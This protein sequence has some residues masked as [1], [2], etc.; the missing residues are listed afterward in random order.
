M[1]TVRTRFAPSPTGYM[2]IGNL[3]TALYEYLIA[4]SQGGTFILRIEDTDAERFVEGSV[5]AIYKTLAMCGLRHD[6]G[7][8]VGG[9]YGPYVQSQRKE[10]YLDHAR[11]LVAAGGAYYCFCSKERIDGLRD[12]CEA[13]HEV[14]KYDGHCKEIPKDEVAARIRNGEACVVRQAIPAGSTTIHDELFGD[15]TVDH[16]Q[17]DENVLLKSDGLPTYNFANVVDDHLM[18]ITHVVRGSEYLSSAPKYDLLYRAFGWEIPSYVHLPLIM[19][20]HSRKLSKRHGDPS[21]EDLIGAGFLKDA[22]LNYILLLG[23]NP[24]DGREFFTLDEMTR[25]F[26]IAGLNKSPAIFDLEKLKWMNGEYVRKLNVD[27]FNE[28]ARPY[29][30]QAIKRNDIDLR[31]VAALVQQRTLILSDIP[32]R[33]DFI[34]AL[35]DYDRGLFVN[36]KAK[37]DLVNSREFLKICR[38]ELEK[39]G[40]WDHEAIQKALFAVIEGKSV[41]ANTFLTPLR[42]ALSGREVTPGGA[43]ELAE[44]LG[45]QET[46]ARIQRGIGRLSSN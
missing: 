37:T 24:K 21:F 12:A 17:L 45:K 33:I 6:E 3:R 25:A 23:W 35:P 18:R 13:R 15:I 39:V 40:T 11:K 30:K 7:P 22:V 32:A 29:I 19:K 38:E 9:P 16:G 41:K 5:A 10:I 44:I 4:R 2:H 27:S 28:L 1:P 8:D 43:T 46:L 34:D 26:S 42:I 36:K 20:D 14:F 31:K